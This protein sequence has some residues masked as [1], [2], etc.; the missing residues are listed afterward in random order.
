MEVVM[1]PAP[2]FVYLFSWL[3]SYE[4]V[5][6]S[7]GGKVG[8]SM[9]TKWTHT[10]W[11]HVINPADWTKC[12]TQMVAIVMWLIGSTLFMV[13]IW[14][15]STQK[16]VRLRS[17]WFWA[18]L[19]RNGQFWSNL[20]RKIGTVLYYLAGTVVSKILSRSDLI[21]LELV[22]Y[23]KDLMIGV[24]NKPSS[25]L[26]V[27]YHALCRN[28][29]KNKACFINAYIIFSRVLCWIHLV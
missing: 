29:T 4:W 23:C 25:V 20:L 15:D 1:V 6:G 19:I 28:V 16:L 21:R 10:T 22:A 11:S 17:D 27:I 5:A 2:C 26:P 8:S 24:N 13:G 12:K 18:D 9:I 7:G 3:S 14:S